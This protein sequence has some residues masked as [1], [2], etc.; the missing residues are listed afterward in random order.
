MLPIVKVFFLGEGGYGV[1]M[2]ESLRRQLRDVCIS[3]AVDGKPTVLVIG[4]SVDIGRQEWEDIY[5]LMIGGT[6]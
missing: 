4:S 3:A 6:C 5:K 1:S 2:L